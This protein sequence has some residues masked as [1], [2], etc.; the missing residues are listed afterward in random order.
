MR[1]F[2]ELCGYEPD[3]IERESDRVSRALAKAGITEPDLATAKQRL[4]TYYDVELMGVRKVLC[5]LLKEFTNI[6]LARDEG[7][8]RVAFSFMAP[9]CQILGA[10][11]MENYEGVAWVEAD[12]VYLIVVGAI[13]NKAA[14]VMEAA[15]RLWLKAG[16]VGHCGNVKTAVG[17]LAL[18]MV[19][20]PDVAISSG[21]LCETSVK[22]IGL[23]QDWYG[24]PAL[25]YDTWQDREL[26]EYPHAKRATSFYAKS[27]RRLAEQVGERFGITVTDDMLWRVMAQRKAFGA[28]MDKVNGL[29]RHGD[30]VPLRS[31]HINLLGALES[32]PC[33]PGQLEEMTVALET[34][35]E[36]LLDRTGKG[37]GAT[38]KGAPRVLCTLP[39]H[40]SDPR[41][42]ELAN[43]LGVA[44]VASDFEFAS[45]QRVDGAGV[46]DPD[47]P[48]DVIGQHMHGAAQQILG[49]RVALI[50]DACRE[51]RL[52]GVLNHYHVGCRYVAGDAL[53]I[54]NAVTK[55][56]GL[57]VL[58][59]EWDNFD[60]RSY[61]HEQYKSNL[62]TFVGMMRAKAL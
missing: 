10:A 58:T 60:P 19:P 1:E 55:E 6:A 18:G 16:G 50:V 12:Y 15:E 49:G 43:R 59:F 57:P 13:F 39:C 56:L 17:L 27:M 61:N 7:Y 23:L 52:D 22:T 62:E 31:A 25:Y 34:L 44:I 48:Y 26:R 5:V 11:I 3:E 33:R 4:A 14:A 32:I 37:I 2:L 9:G 24:I 30:P 42:E 41:W 28:A 38:P 35:H 45:S 40:H 51:L 36:D 46:L 8:D 21:F 54:K 29:L 47:D 53:T 20:R